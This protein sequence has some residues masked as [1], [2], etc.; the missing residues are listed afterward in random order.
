MFHQNKNTSIQI[1]A[2]L[3][4]ILLMGLKV[5]AWYLT[6]SNAIMTDALE[7]TV[8][9]VAGGFA[10]YS[11]ILSSKPKDK[12]HPYGHGKIEFLSAGFE[13]SLITLAGLS[14]IIKSVYNLFH[15]QHIE[16][17]DIGLLLVA[18]SGLVNYGLGVLLEKRGH[19]ANSLTLIASGQHL[20]ADAWTSLG[21]IIG[22]GLIL[23]TG[24]LFL[25]NIIAILFALFIIYTG[26]K[27]LRTSIAGIMD[28]ADPELIQDIVDNLNLKRK[29]NWIDVHNFRVIKYGTTLHIDC[30]LTLPWYYDTRKAHDE[31]DR[32]E[33]TI[34]EICKEPVELF[35][36]VDPCI[37]TSCKL[38]Q[39]S[40]CLQRQNPV[41]TKIIWTLDNIIENQK[42]GL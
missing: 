41:E 12:D 27:L 22:L 36:H 15:P 39:I 20:K 30:H 23:T 21:L 40:H 1:I 11:L 3:T 8:N 37:P 25:D 24:L 33:H 7:S 29:N 9:I 19:I 2:I 4:G 35:I 16:Q 10:L 26:Y 32:F 28:E 34:N 42:H 14:I 31:V 13:A 6:G 17:L 38:C 5:F 18:L